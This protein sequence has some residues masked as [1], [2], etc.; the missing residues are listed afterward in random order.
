MN[1][2]TRNLPASDSFMRSQKGTLLRSAVLCILYDRRRIKSFKPSLSMRHLENMLHV[3]TD[4]LNFT[5]WYLKQ[6]GF[7]VNDDKSSME[8]TVEGMDYLERNQPPADGVMAF[9]KADAVVDAQPAPE[10]CCAR[11]VCES[12]NRRLS[13]PC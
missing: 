7:V 1:R 10:R 12:P 4:E 5:L 6:R 9:V 3:T 2:A 8:I 11:T 13:S